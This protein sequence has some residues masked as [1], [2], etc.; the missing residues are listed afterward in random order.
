MGENP[1]N[2]SGPSPDY[3]R[4]DIVS[5]VYSNIEKFLNELHGLTTHVKDMKHLIPTADMCPVLISTGTEKRLPYVA[6]KDFTIVAKDKGKVVEYNE[7]S[8]MMI[9]EYAD[10]THEAVNLNPIIVKNGGGGFYLSNVLVSNLKKGSTFRKNDIIASNKDFFRTGWDGTKFAIGTL[11]KAAIMSS[12]ATY[13]DAKLVT[14]N[15]ANRLRSEFVMKK[16]VILGKNATVASMM[17]KGDKVK[18]GD[19]L[20]K[21]EQSNSE[22]AMNVMLRNIGDT[23]KEDIKD[24]GKSVLKSKYTGVIEDIRIYSTFNLDELSPSLRKIVGDYWK[25]I[26]AKKE[27]VRKYKITDPTY[28]GSTFFEMDTVTKP[29]DSDKI[30]GYKV[31]E[32]GVIIEFYVKYVDIVGVGDKLCDFA[33][34]KG[35]T[36]TVVPKGQEPYTPSRPNE[37]IG[38]IFPASSVLARMVSSIIPT[39]FGN[40]IIVELKRQL[41]EI[42]ES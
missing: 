9:L 23:L 38:T 40:K 41:Q 11:T 32:G 34:L 27:L 33:A 19:P 22:E 5:T 42:Y 1:L 10:K 37:E 6:S 30:K 4:N 16:H 14:E 3:W 24:F 28:S 31:E 39:M 8:H 26:R 18:V 25:E 20:I 13:E 36:C 7:K 17:K 35:V 2:R 29:D 12:F 15:L 21:Y